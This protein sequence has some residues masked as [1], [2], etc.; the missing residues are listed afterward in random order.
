VGSL[1][2]RQSAP[3]FHPQWAGAAA[4]GAEQ[5]GGFKAQLAEAAYREREGD[6]PQADERKIDS[7]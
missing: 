7:L 6:H 4:G 5:A 2:D 1:P 3:G